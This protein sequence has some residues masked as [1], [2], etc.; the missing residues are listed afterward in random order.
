MIRSIIVDDEKHSRE[1]LKDQVTSYCT[2]IEVIDMAECLK[3]AKICIEE[4]HPDL[5]FLDIEMPN[6]SG[7]DLLKS[8]DKIFFK[9]VFVTGHNDL[10]I[11]AFSYSASHYL[12]KPVDPGELRQAVEK[13]RN[14]INREIEFTNT[15]L[16]LQWAQ[17]TQ[18]TSNT[19][20]IPHIDGFK[21]ININE[22]I[23]LKA[24]S[25]CTEIILR[26]GRSMLSTRN[27]L[28]YDDLLQ[29]RSFF[30]VHNSYLINLQHVREF[31]K[32]GTIVLTENQ[33]VPLGN[34]YRKRFLD[35]FGRMK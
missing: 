21:V 23:C 7:F 17:S 29:K 24:D 3:A 20:V 19:I 11:E 4:K 12:L 18:F 10:A 6:G 34:T 2:D 25:Y 26:G 9:V 1:V 27:L 14:E 35:F 5:V 31:I 32:D 8:F 13:V 22:I 16:L 30:R 28:H 15:E 33:S